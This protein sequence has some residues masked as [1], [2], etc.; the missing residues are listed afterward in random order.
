[1]AVSGSG[2]GRSGA[3]GCPGRAEWRDGDVEGL[4]A[5]VLAWPRR[6]PSSSQPPVSQCHLAL[7]SWAQFG[8]WRFRFRWCGGC[9]AHVG[10]RRDVHVGSQRYRDTCVT[11]GPAPPR[12]VTHTHRYPQHTHTPG[13]THPCTSPPHGVPTHTEAQCHTH[14]GR[15]PQ[16]TH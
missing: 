6:C 1:M 4:R 7:L 16:H 9:H 3:G 12:P 13:H 14:T 2:E 8:P 10:T 15:Y 5:G 11:R